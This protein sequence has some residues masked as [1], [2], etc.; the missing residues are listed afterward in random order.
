MIFNELGNSDAN[1]TLLL[2]N[3][4]SQ[5]D[6]QQQPSYLSW[7]ALNSLMVNIGDE[8]FDYDSFKNSYDTNPMIKQLIQRFDA[9][10][11]ELKT[12]NKNPKKGQPGGEGE[13]AKMAKAATARRQNE[14]Y[15]NTRQS[16]FEGIDS[17]TVNEALVWKRILRPIVEAQLTP[18]QINGLFQA[19][20]QSATDA[21][22]NRTL[23]GKGVDVANAASQA[24][25]K[26]KAAMQ[27][28]GPIQGFE[29]QYDKLAAKIKEKTGGDQGVMKYIQQ[30]RDF[31]AKH[32]IAQKVIYAAA[33]AALGALA[34]GGS[35]AAV[36][37][38][39]IV[40]GLFKMTD[41]LLQGD[42]L[43]SA[44]WQGVKTAGMAGAA[45]GVGKAVRGALGL[46]APTGAGGAA[47]EPTARTSKLVNRP[48]DFSDQ[49]QGGGASAAASNLSPGQMAKTGLA[50]L[51]DMVAKGEVTDYNSYQKALST[52]ARDSGAS[53]MA[54]DTVQRIIDLNAGAEAAR[55]AGGQ[56]GGGSANIIKKFIALNGGTPDEASFGAD[57]KARQSMIS[58]MQGDEK[59]FAAKGAAPQ[60]TGATVQ[61][62]A[63]PAAEPELKG[64]ALAD[65]RAADMAKA[66]A[67]GADGSVDILNGP[68]EIQGNKQLSAAYKALVS[69]IQ[70]DPNYN[71][72]NLPID[73]QRFASQNSVGGLQATKD[74]SLLSLYVQKAGG[75]N[76][77]GFLDAV[78][79][80]APQVA[81]GATSN[82]A[83]F[84][85][86]YES[87]LSEQ[88]ARQMSESQIKAIFRQVDEGVWD[89]VKKGASAVAGSK[90]GQA[91]SKGAGAVAQKV[92]TAAT[93]ITTKVTAD[94]LMKA[95]KAAKSPTDSAQVYKI[96][97]AQG[98]DDATLASVF[99]TAGIEVPPATPVAAPAP[100]VAPAAGKGF[101]VK[102][103]QKAAPAA[104]A[105]PA[106]APK[107]APVAPAPQAAA[108][109][110]AGQETDAQ[111]RARIKAKQQAF[112]S[113][114]GLKESMEYLRLSLIYNQI[115][116]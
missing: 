108:P 23:A 10:G 66:A 98:L 93:N 53:G 75:G 61:P 114:Q 100:T 54:R 39:P 97:K 68:P 99:K 11:V 115:K 78:K 89:T 91:V 72:R 45:V 7:D 9:R 50:R 40:L 47:T 27:N 42:K 82:P 81:R 52:I 65:K 60:S 8:Q 58:Q 46:G 31:A 48:G 85:S 38:G 18:D 113:Q 13:V 57:E 21:G 110:A 86:A 77:N 106:P 25:E 76:M 87:R 73:I 69:K 101:N 4:I 102:L 74:S 2:R 44:A 64:K 116:H 88:L 30:Y 111:R 92:G 51:K 19:A 94:K 71:V 56:I 34:V 49:P 104:P 12:K 84:E 41:R 16:L 112:K 3:Q 83:D 35:I 36:S 32:P 33:I 107:A 28:S 17:Q 103:P 22:G 29:A 55:A 79:N 70:S 14:S 37:G 26:V 62:Q 80:A 95:W 90:V 105:A 6:R 67:A 20:Q 24:F 5:A 109:A 1:L 43:T 59:A 96:M 63:A 15:S